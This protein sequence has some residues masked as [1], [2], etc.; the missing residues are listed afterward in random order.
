[1][2]FSSIPFLYY[3]L[4]AFFLVYF[5]VKDKYKNIVILFGSLLFYACSGIQYL[6]LIIFSILLGYISGIEIEKRKCKKIIFI[7]AIVLLLLLL[8]YFKYTNFFIENIALI[9]HHSISTFQIILPIGISFYTFQIISY[10]VD[11]YRGEIHSQN[12]FI[13][14]AAYVV[15]FPQLIAG[16]IVRYQDIAFELE[17]RTHKDCMIYAGITR[18][19]VGLC[20][21]VLI[22]N[23]MASYC[24][25]F[26]DTDEKSILFYWMY[27]ICFTLFIYFDFSGYSD[28]AIGL[29]KIMG[30]HF[31]ENFNYPYLAISITEFWRRWHMTLGFWFRDYVYIPLGGNRVSMIRWIFHILVVWMLTGLWHGAAWNFVVWGLLFAFLLMIEKLTGFTK[32]VP[33]ICLHIYVMFI[34]IISFVIF[35]ANH[36]SSAIKTLQAMF[37]G[38]DI[39][40]VTEETIY[41]TNSYLVAIIIA[42]FGCT[43]LP[44]KIYLFYKEKWPRTVDLLKPLIIVFLL[45]LATAY[46]VDGSYNPFLYFRF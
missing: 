32:K 24:D 27:A 45:L 10:L 16:P 21:K 30:F 11:V 34:V 1:M 41:Y 29:G 6:F 43:P 12:N 8:V 17:K 14:F 2:V 39:P 19:I 15:L 26:K 33:K 3:F 4:P 9:M 20:K 31:P 22:A 23:T 25:I 42:V 40:L 5:I 7:N 38:R 13:H 37:G 36:I 18:F 35:D 46:L 44:K 28:M